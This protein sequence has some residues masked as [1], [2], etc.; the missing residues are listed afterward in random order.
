M[1]AMLGWQESLRRRSDAELAEIVGEMG[2]ALKRAGETLSSSLSHE[3]YSGLR[4]MDVGDLAKAMSD[5]L[6]K[7]Y[8]GFRSV[9]EAP[10]SRPRSDL[11]EAIEKMREVLKGAYDT[12]AGPTQDEFDD[13]WVAVDRAILRAQG[14]PK[15]DEEDG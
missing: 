11:I 5:D 14:L 2:A 12:L 4:S 8:E 13:M 3:E 15:E 9:C 10:E 6:L 1:T 7:D